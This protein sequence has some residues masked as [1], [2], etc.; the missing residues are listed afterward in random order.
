LIA[1]ASVVERLAP[2][3]VQH[4]EMIPGVWQVE[5]PRMRVVREWYLGWMMARLD[6]GR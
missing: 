1:T 6:Q 5:A 4:L 3:E 2:V